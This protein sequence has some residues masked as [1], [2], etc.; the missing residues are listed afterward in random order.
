MSSPL[1][2]TE[3]WIESF[4]IT[5]NLCPFA[6]KPF[7]DGAIRYVLSR[8]EDRYGVG[9][10]VLN[11]VQ[12]L[13]EN[14]SVQTSFVVIPHLLSDF[15][16]YLEWFDST[17]ELLVH[18]NADSEFQLV[19]FHPDYIFQNTAPDAAENYTNRS[20][21]PMVH[22]L[23][24]RDVSWAVDNFPDTYLIPEKNIERLRE[25]GVKRIREILEKILA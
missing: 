20:P 2:Q 8:G 4:V 11:E 13:R 15:L 18:F 9:A 24:E 14:S 1:E 16:E 6:Q 21:F 17:Q 3:A 22:I 12:I 10:E 19:S 5:Q 7:G 23:R 25:L